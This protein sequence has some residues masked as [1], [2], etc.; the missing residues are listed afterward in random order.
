MQST[1]N[2]IKAARCVL[3]L[4]KHTF[5]A[6]RAADE[7]ART[8]GLEQI[9]DTY[10]RSAHPSTLPAGGQD[11]AEP[12]TG[13]VGAI[14]LDI[15]GHLAAASSS[16]GLYG[17]DVSRIGDSTIPGSSIWAD[18]SLAIVWYGQEPDSPGKN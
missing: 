6:G 11:H 13:T 3:E 16:G 14:V 17:K 1:R 7:L 10:Y 9:D 5:I 2:P 8:N 18:D 15:H 12:P 4:R